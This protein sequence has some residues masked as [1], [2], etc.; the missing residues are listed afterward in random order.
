MPY[1][2][3][4]YTRRKSASYRRR[5]TRFGRRTGGYRRTAKRTRR[6][7]GSAGGFPKIMR[8]KIS[9][10][11]N[12]SG[13]TDASYILRGNGPYD[14]E[15]ATGGGQPMAWAQYLAIYGSYKVTGS[16]IKLQTI[17]NDTTP[18]KAI[19]VANTSNSHLS[20][21][22]VAPDLVQT[23]NH[24]YQ[25]LTGSQ[26]GKNI[27]VM[28]MY[29]RTSKFYPGISDTVTATT[30]ANPADQ[31]Y[32]HIVMKDSTAWEFYAKVT[33]YVKF[34]ERKDIKQT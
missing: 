31:W 6:M 14:P 26:A 8:T 21:L 9:Y 16:S 27:G 33:Y 15:E 18:C 25:A 12:R 11:L 17:N 24:R 28:S 10:V 13:T 19:I 3:R 34:F 29:R 30:S 7:R 2:R 20:T 22:D 1:A 23:T 4:R 32:W 5:T